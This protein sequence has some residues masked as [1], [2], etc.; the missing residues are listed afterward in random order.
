MYLHWNCR[1]HKNIVY[2]WLTFGVLFWR[3]STND[4]STSLAESS[5]LLLWR[6]P[7]GLIKDLRLAVEVLFLDLRWLHKVHLLLRYFILKL[8]LW[9][10][11]SLRP[12]CTVCLAQF[13][14][15]SADY[16]TWL[17][18]WVTVLLVIYW[19]LLRAF[20]QHPLICFTVAFLNWYRR[21]WIH[22]F[23]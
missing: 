21:S 3:F 7:N 5:S 10:H 8:L 23:I 15:F 6:V 11:Y 17:C 13:A 22:H 9:G 16:W 14:R 18:Y 4:L 19:T 1:N 2:R 20:I 12:T